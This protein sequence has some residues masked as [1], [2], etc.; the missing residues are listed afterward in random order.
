[1]AID[2]FQGVGLPREP[3][4]LDDVSGCAKHCLAFCGIFGKEVDVIRPKEVTEHLGSII[5][6]S[7]LQTVFH[8]NTMVFEL[9]ET[10]VQK[11]VPKRGCVRR[12]LSPSREKEQTNFG[13]KAI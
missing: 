6:V 7:H 12:A 4:P 13:F 9:L 1:M 5:T 11:S 10:L 8:G 3:M 2:D